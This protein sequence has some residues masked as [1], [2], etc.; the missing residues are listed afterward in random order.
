MEENGSAT[1]SDGD[2]DYLVKLL[3]LGDSSVGKTALLTRF[4]EGSFTK[5]FHQTVGIDFKEKR[6]RWRPA[7]RSVLGREQRVQLQLWDT[8]GQE[9]FRSLTTAFYRDAMGFVLVFDLT[10][11]QS[12]TNV[13][14]WIEQ[15]RLHAYCERPD[16]VLLGNKADLA[17][18]RVVNERRAHQLAEQ[19]E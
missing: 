4:T 11:E 3:T 19:F 10:S 2:Y 15:L 13:R 18:S 1:R 9:R 6:L 12:F 14:S 5:R 17:D 8:A 16:V 7:G